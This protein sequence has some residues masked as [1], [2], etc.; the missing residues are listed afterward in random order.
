MG[1]FVTLVVVWILAVCFI[2]AL[3]LGAL[4][5]FYRV[6]RH[7]ATASVR[8]GVRASH[9]PPPIPGR[10]ASAGVPLAGRPMP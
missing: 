8:D 6:V 4:Y 10:K 9:L 3:G 7:V 1:I 2:L 5:L